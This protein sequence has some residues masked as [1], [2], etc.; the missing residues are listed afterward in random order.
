MRI[1]GELFRNAVEISGLPPQ[2]LISLVWMILK[3]SQVA[4]HPEMPWSG[5]TPI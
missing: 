5:L 1:V 4:N 2:I 3:H